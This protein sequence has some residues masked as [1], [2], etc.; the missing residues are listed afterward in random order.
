MQRNATQRNA[1]QRNATQRNTLNCSKCR[2]QERSRPKR[3]GGEIRED[4][5]SVS[6]SVFIFYFIFSCHF[7][8]SFAA[9][10]QDKESRGVERTESS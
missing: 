7:G 6:V 1:T 9:G 3:K 10:N 8:A 4:G 2:F 5:V